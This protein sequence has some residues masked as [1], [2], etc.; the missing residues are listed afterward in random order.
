[1][2]T[3]VALAGGGAGRIA[4]TLARGG[5]GRLGRLLGTSAAGAA[6]PVDLGEPE[7]EQPDLR[8]G[9]SR[10]GASSH[11]NKGEIFN[12]CPPRLGLAVATAAAPPTQPP[13]LTSPRLFGIG[14][15]PLT[16]T[17]ADLSMS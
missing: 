2:A 15:L 6:G 8:H 3:M 14:F 17:R 5:L 7:P 11:F 16:L 1:M 10:T 4:T 9:G 13:H 12:H